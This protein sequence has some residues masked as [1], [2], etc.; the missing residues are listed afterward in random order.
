MEEQ[1]AG[2]V[3]KIDTLVKNSTA[4]L[5]AERVLYKE[6]IDIKE[7]MKSLKKVFHEN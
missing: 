6:V 7:E 2:V 4:Q 5:Q 3:L 1:L